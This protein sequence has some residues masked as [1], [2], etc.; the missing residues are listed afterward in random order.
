MAGLSLCV[1]FRGFSI[2]R[3][4]PRGIGEA[5]LQLVLPVLCALLCYCVPHA[6]SN[7]GGKFLT[8]CSIS[9]KLLGLFGFTLFAP[10]KKYYFLQFSRFLY[11]LFM[12]LLSSFF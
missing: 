9:V 2:D 6:G 4:M 8:D 1:I 7:S 5:E 3:L 12:H 11:V 10:V